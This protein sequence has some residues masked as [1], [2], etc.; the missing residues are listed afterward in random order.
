MN[1]ILLDILAHHGEPGDPR[2]MVWIQDLLDS[3]I[4]SGPAL[5][6]AALGLVIVAMPA[7]ILALYL[8]RRARQEDEE[9]EADKV[10]AEDSGSGDGSR[11]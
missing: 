4:G 7:G 2:L 5:V 10:S 9:P 8:I 11:L 3:M 1:V 6:V